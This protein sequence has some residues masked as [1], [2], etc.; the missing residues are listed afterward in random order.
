M[1]GE[2]EKEEPHQLKLVG[3]STNSSNNKIERQLLNYSLVYYF[4]FLSFIIQ[5]PGIDSTHLCT[6]N[7]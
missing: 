4:I 2:E 3:P 6:I 5:H 7:S 1:C